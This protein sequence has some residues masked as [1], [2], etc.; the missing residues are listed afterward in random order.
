MKI[1]RDSDLRL[2]ATRRRVARAAVLVCLFAVA[3]VTAGCSKGGPAGPQGKVHGK[4]TYQEKPI[5]TGSVVS[6]LSE[7]GGTGA[8]GTVKDDGSY[9]LLSTNGNQIP[10]GSYKVLISPPQPKPMSPEEAMKA[11]MEKGK[12]KG[13]T[14]DPTIPKQYRSSLSTPEKHEVKEG[15][16]EIN[17]E[18]KDK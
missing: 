13:P 12:P 6:F 5:T 16:N 17:I 18:L 9:E 15:D 3:T 7:G 4:V 8:S 11:S 1:G 14:E 10:V 2:A